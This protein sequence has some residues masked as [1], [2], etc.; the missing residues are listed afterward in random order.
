M[1]PLCLIFL[2]AG[3]P[4]P[5]FTDPCASD[6][7]AC[8]QST[9]AFQLDPSC[10]LTGTLSVEAGQGETAYAPLAAGESIV[11]HH[12]SQ[13]GIHT[14]L[15]LRVTN[16]AL[17]VYDKLKVRL[18]LTIDDGKTIIGDRT[19]VLGAKKAVRVAVD[20]A[21]EEFGIVTFLD[22]WPTDRTRTLTVTVTDPCGRVGT[23]EHVIP[24]SPPSG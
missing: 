24:A 1:H 11:I 20:G 23:A 3:C 8:D 17:D 13:G 7:F 4:G 5:S 19:L 15:A 6:Q 12:G 9:D 16:A 14:V 21:V 18:A 2:L 10:K 22:W